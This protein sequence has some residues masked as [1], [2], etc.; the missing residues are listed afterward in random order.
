MENHRFA[1]TLMALQGVLFAIETAMIH[2]IGQLANVMQLSLLRS[3]ACLA[4]VAV[5]ARNIGWSIFRTEQLPLQILRGF[6][7]V[8]YAW[9]MMYSYSRLPFADATAISYTQTAYITVFSVLILHEKVTWLNWSAVALG[10]IGAALLVKPAF[11][12]WNLVYLVA[13]FG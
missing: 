3:T 2:H 10:I 11:L 6:L 7:S 5:L 13:L 9:V 8:T 4:V 12:S 1:V